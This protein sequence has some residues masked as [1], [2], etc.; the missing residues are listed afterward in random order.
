MRC[1]IDYA[2][3]RGIKE[4]F[5]DVLRENTTMLKLCQVFGFTRSTLPEMSPTSC[6]LASPCNREQSV[7]CAVS[8]T[9][10]ACEKL[11]SRD[12]VLPFALKLTGADRFVPAADDLAPCLIYRLRRG[13][14]LH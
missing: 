1:I 6:V 9:S 8:M 3:R 13:V 10:E 2:Q 14:L 12:L 7:I 4:L 5:G 11:A